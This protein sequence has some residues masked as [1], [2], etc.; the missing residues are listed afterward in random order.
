MP[1]AVEQLLNSEILKRASYLRNEFGAVR[2]PW[3]KAIACWSLTSS[4]IYI[5]LIVKY[6]CS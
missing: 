4:E 1:V 2:K 3:D 6:Y 5:A